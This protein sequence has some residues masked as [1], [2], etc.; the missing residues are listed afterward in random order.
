[1]T[2][3]WFI[4]MGKEKPRD[5]AGITNILHLM[6]AEVREGVSGGRVEEIFSGLKPKETTALELRYGLV[7]GNLH[8]HEKIGAPMGMTAMGAIKLI[9]RILRKVI[10]RAT[11]IV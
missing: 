8:S 9:K 10:D 5:K 2:D 1:M 11:E 4:V 6:P 3:F 7:D